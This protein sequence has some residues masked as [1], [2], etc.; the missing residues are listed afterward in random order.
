M[1]IIY[2]HCVYIY[3]YIYIY[4][5]TYT[6]VAIKNTTYILDNVGMC[7]CSSREKSPVISKIL[8]SF[9]VSPNAI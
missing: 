2:D 7:I 6:Y 8:H 1:Y 4:I 3:I 9:I 5:Y